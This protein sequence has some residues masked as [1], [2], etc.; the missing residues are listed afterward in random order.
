MSTTDSGN[1]SLAEYG[2]YPTFLA[3]SLSWMDFTSSPSMVTTPFVGERILLM[4]CINVDFPTPFGP[5]IERSWGPLA[6]R[7]TF[8]STG[9]LE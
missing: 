1:A 8:S 4:Q 3:S 9:V 2:T 7:V 5:M 6:Y